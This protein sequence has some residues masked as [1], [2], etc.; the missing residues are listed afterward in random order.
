M[1]VLPEG[2]NTLEVTLYVAEKLH[3]SMPLA[4]GLLDVVSG[5]DDPKAFITSFIKDFVE[6]DA[7]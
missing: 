7:E 1:G 4:R 5:R 2:F 3:L 6:Y